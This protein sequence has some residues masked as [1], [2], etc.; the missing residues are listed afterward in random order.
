MV[1]GGWQGRDGRKE[2]T[3]I[4]KVGAEMQGLFL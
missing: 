2:I 3:I 1:V 4:I